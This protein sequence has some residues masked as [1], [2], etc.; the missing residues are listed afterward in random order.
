M[1]SAPGLV[2]VVVKNFKFAA[3]AQASGVYRAR[4]ETARGSDIPR[5][6]TTT[7]RTWGKASLSIR[8]EGSSG[9]SNQSPALPCPVATS[10]L[11]PI[12]PRIRIPGGLPVKLRLKPTSAGDDRD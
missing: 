5:R 12:Q 1:K 7:W 10:D 4:S 6:Y 3:A 2:T 11:P 8:S 9:E